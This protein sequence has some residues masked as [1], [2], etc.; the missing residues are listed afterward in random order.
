MTMT[1][2]NRDC[3]RLGLRCVDCLPRGQWC[4]LCTERHPMTPADAAQALRAVLA[5]LPMEFSEAPGQGRRRERFTVIHRRNVLAV[6]EGL[7]LLQQYF[8]T[9]AEEDR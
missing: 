1:D 9:A 5:E 7:G 2:P 3:R 6:H 8:E 4:D